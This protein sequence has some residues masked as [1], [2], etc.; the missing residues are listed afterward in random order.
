MLGNSSEQEKGQEY[1]T[2]N[3]VTLLFYSPLFMCLSL[4]LSLS[5][6]EMK[7]VWYVSSPT[8]LGSE[9]Q[10]LDTLI[11]RAEAQQVKDTEAH[12]QPSLMQQLIKLT[13]ENLFS[14]R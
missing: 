10:S 3:C 14:V 2:Q 6:A 7:A 12:S 11:R 8:S 5:L 1:K 4:S 9:L 13:Q